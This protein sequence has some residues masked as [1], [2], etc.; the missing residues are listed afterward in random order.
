MLPLRKA[1]D[2]ADKLDKYRHQDGQAPAQ[3]GGSP[4]PSSTACTADKSVILD[5]ITACQ[6]SL[7]TR[8]EK[9]KV[10]TSLLSQDLQQLQDRVG[11]LEH[12]LGWVEA[13]LPHCRSPRIKRV[14]L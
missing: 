14:A 8:I 13:T 7:T 12:S 10:D 11:E 5:G 4:S 6:T 2:T 3:D 9:M 1:A